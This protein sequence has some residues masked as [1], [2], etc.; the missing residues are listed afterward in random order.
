MP[1]QAVVICSMPG[2]D[3]TVSVVRGNHPTHTT[4]PCHIALSQAL[5]YLT[6]RLVVMHALTPCLVA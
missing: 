4:G 3:N 5:Q 2:R 6:P 1:Y